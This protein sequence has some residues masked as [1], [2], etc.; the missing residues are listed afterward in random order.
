MQRIIQFLSDIELLVY[1]GLGFITILYVR[2]LILA[3][4]EFRNSVFGLERE[5]AQRKIIKI[6]GILAFMGLLLLSEFVV[7]TFLVTEL[8]QQ[9]TYATSTIEVLSTNTATLPSVIPTDST[10]TPT[11]YPQANIE[12]V[13]SNCE[14]E[15]LAF[16]FPVQGEEV[17]GVVEIIGTVNTPNFGSYKYEY[18]PIGEINWITV[19][20]GSDL[21]KDESIGFWYTNSLI[22]GDYLL[23]L[24]ALDN[25]GIEQQTCVINLRVVPSQ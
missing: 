14:A 6:V 16:S 18:S 8:P 20:A 5:I 22:P 19:A 25:Q 23:K 15:I 9:A 2:R 12:G 17:S 21:R 13:E 1:F 24:V 11:P 7:S 3:I 10:N 4:T